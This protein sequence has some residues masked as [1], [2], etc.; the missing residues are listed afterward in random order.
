MKS[1]LSSSFCKKLTILG[2]T[3]FGILAITIFMSCLSTASEYY[4]PGI[5]EAAGQ[6]FRGTIRVRVHISEGGIENIEI[7][8]NNENNHALEAIEELRDLALE[9]NSADLDAISGATV[10]SRGF[11]SALEAALSRASE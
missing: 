11:L 4:K 7:L 9:Y 10:S 1:R 6:G 2:L 3:V 5:Y 8:E